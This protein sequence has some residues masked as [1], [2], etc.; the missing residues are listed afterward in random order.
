MYRQQK[1]LSCKLNNLSDQKAIGLTF[2]MSPNFNSLQYFLLQI[3]SS[4]CI[5][6]SRRVT[7]ST[8]IKPTTNVLPQIYANI[9][10]NCLIAMNFRIGLSMLRM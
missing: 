2:A 1:T 5:G 3:I 6:R 4:Y 9:D 8:I 10:Y 7:V